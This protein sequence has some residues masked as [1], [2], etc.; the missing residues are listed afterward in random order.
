MLIN[1]RNGGI[2]KNANFQDGRQIKDGCRVVGKND[3]N[4]TFILA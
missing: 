1:I 3:H 2:A 4:V